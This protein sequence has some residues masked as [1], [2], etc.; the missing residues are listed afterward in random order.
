MQ[1][2]RKKE[3]RRKLS[4]RL[5]E[6]AKKPRATRLKG[7]FSKKIRLSDFLWISPIFSLQLVWNLF[8][9]EECFLVFDWLLFHF[10]NQQEA[11]ATSLGSGF[12]S[13]EDVECRNL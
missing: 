4:K 1:I 8:G 7:N 2:F 9:L 10:S 5:A 6:G 11:G 3:R 13:T 12:N